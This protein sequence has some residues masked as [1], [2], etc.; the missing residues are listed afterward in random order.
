M[1]SKV[2]FVKMSSSTLKFKMMRL[3]F[4]LAMF[5]TMMMFALI[6]SASLI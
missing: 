5:M 6:A 3:R 1:T 2:K 4:G